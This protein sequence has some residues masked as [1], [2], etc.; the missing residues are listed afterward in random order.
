MAVVRHLQANYSL[1]NSPNGGSTSRIYFSILGSRWNV[2]V[3]SL[4]FAI[5]K[6]IIAY[7]IPQIVVPPLGYISL[8]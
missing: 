5:Y 4:W 1:L 8:Y 7:L 6:P 2:I 3:E